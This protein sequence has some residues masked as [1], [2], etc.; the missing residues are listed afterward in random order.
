MHARKI[1]CAL[2]DLIANGLKF[3]LTATEIEYEKMMIKEQDENKKP[4]IQELYRKVCEEN[5]RNYEQ[6]HIDKIN[7]DDNNYKFVSKS[8]KRKTYIKHN[9]EEKHECHPHH[10]HRHPNS[11]LKDISSKSGA[12][13]RSI[14]YIY[15]IEHII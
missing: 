6:K 14:M 12:T 8:E 2:I 7:I 3:A 13:T 4:R 5:T 9:T 1:C 15:L 11:I 10:N